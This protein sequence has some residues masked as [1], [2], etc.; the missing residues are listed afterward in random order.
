MNSR[1]LRS[2]ALAAFAAVALT[3]CASAEGP[4]EGSSDNSGEDR[5]VVWYADVMDANPIATAVTQAL[6]ARLAEN[7]ISMVRSLSLDPS[8]GKIDVAV[9]AQAVARAVAAKPDAIAYFVLDPTS[10]RPQIESAMA[11]DIPV[12]AA[13]GKPDFDVNAFIEMNNEAQG[14]AAAA[15]LAESLPQG[16]KVAIIGGPATPNIL[17]AEAGATRAFKEA[18]V[19]IVGDVDQQRD[20]SDSSG[21]TQAI[22]QGILQRDPDVQG[23]YVYSDDAAFGAIAAAN[24]VGKDILFTSRN[25]SE[26]AV[27]AVKAGTLLAT[28]DVQ[29]IELGYRLADAI[30]GQLDGTKPLEGS[31][32]IPPAD[33]SDCLVTKDNANAWK[34]YEDILDYQDI[35]LR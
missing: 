5:P 28:C 29:P 30:I 14:H 35:P 4:S 25:G 15:Y 9:Q 6:N 1:L 10:P 19:T 12:F 3:S 18:G 33:A 21:G 11:A 20:L 31:S 24:Q 27:D 34:S 8:S 17:D 7:G 2:F 23:V 32:E 26:A 16:A 22:M 13:F